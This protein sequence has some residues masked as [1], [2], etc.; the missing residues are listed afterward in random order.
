MVSGV[1]AVGN[2]WDDEVVDGDSHENK[3]IIKLNQI[4]ALT[5]I[6]IDI[7]LEGT[8]HDIVKRKWNSY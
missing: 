1:V 4:L 5:L 3:N 2:G 7:A 6:L 8:E